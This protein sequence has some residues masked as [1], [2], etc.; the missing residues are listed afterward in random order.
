MRSAPAR[1]RR[2]ALV[3]AGLGA[4]GL[5]AGSA[6][7]GAT[8]D[9]RDIHSRVQA[10]TKARGAPLMGATCGPPR[11]AEAVVASEDERLYER[12]GIDSIGLGRALLY[13]V[14]NL[15]R[16]QGGSTITAQLV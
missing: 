7:W 11:R 16:C 5:A 15:C 8:P 13:A 12:H 9:P 14:T 10:I 2:L 6:L 4:L 1:V 3:I